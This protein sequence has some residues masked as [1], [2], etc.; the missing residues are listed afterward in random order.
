MSSAHKRPRGLLSFCFLLHTKVQKHIRALSFLL[1]QYHGRPLNWDRLPSLLSFKETVIIQFGIILN[2]MESHYPKFLSQQ[3]HDF[4]SFL[5]PIYK[6]FPSFPRPP[7]LPLH[8]DL[9]LHTP[10]GE[11]K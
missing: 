5:L 9:L 10:G 11:T 6:S 7:L 4:L 8:P 3:P 1:Q 2:Y